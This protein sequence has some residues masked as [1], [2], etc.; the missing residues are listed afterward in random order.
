MESAKV[1]TEPPQE[2]G[3]RCFQ[4]AVRVVK[5]CRA[6]EKVPGVRSRLAD[7]LVRSGTSVGAN[8][9]E[10]QAAYSRAEFACKMC[11]ALKE[12]REACYWLRLLIESGVLKSEVLMPLL[13]EAEEIARVIGAITRSTR[14]RRA[15]A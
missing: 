7:Q 6:L 10:A 15:P 13:G 14:Q 9:T 1:K 5:L 8:V 12:S 2:I 11:I 3:E 4:F